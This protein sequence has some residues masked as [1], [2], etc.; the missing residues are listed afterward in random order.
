MTLVATIDSIRI[1]NPVK[2]V[3]FDLPI[4]QFDHRWMAYLLRRGKY[5]GT[6]K[7]C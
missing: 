1:W 7:E 5:P 3:T 6:G 4:D 2:M